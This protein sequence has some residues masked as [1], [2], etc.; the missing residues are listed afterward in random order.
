[1]LLGVSFRRHS[2]LVVQQL[3]GTAEAARWRIGIGPPGTRRDS[4]VRDL[5]VKIIAGCVEQPF[6][7]QCPLSSGHVFLFESSRKTRRL[8]SRRCRLKA[9]STIALR[10]GTLRLLQ[11]ARKPALRSLSCRA[12][13]PDPKILPRRQSRACP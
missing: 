5:R 10:K 1:N 7:R 13:W 12:P 3:F 6:R 9:C 8:E 4:R 2:S 11:L